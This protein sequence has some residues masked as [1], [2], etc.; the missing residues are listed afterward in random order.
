MT[1]HVRRSGAVLVI[2]LHAPESLNAL[3]IDDLLE[4]RRHLAD[5]QDDDTVNAIVLTGSG[6][7]A[8]CTGAN[9]KATMP[10]AL[11]FAAGILSS[12]GKEAGNGG[13]TRLIDLSDLRLWKPLI[14]SINGYC[15][16]G[17]LELA[18]QCDIRIASTTA[19]FALPEVKV[20]SIPAVGGVQYLLR[21]IP[22]VHAMKLALTG[23]RIDA[24]H[25]LRIGLVSDLYASDALQDQATSLAQRIASN[26]PLAVQMVKKLALET[27]HL[28]PEQFIALSNLAW[29][30][31]RDSED[32][33][34]GRRA[35]AE[36]RPPRYRGR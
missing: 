11:P 22:A 15:L 6:D 13:Y 1:V 24:E 20:A 16:G 8:F 36:K 34:E 21:A 35:F 17:G 2:E 7:K 5:A 9:L 14:A 26:G 27:A 25:A 23:E 33:I 19:S 31:L 18:L 12:R 10:P 32:R 3:T 4:L 30:T 28:A 29:G